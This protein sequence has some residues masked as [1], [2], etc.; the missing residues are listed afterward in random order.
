VST[1]HRTRRGER[2]EPPTRPP[3]GS[4]ALALIG[5]GATLLTFDVAIGRVHIPSAIVWVTGVVGALM[6]LMPG[7]I[8]LARP[9]GTR[10]RA[11]G[12]LRERH[13]AGRM[14]LR[15]HKRLERFFDDEGLPLST[16]SNL[17]IARRRRREQ[18]TR[19]ILARYRGH[20]YPWLASVLDDAIALGGAPSS[21]R[22]LLDA[23][24]VEQLMSL[25][26]LFREIADELSPRGA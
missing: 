19:E 6:I 18:R 17:P 20:L 12:S 24:D 21:A 26:D 22:Q 23:R 13:L 2:P 1:V 25:S 7:L 4:H 3:R 16:D 14:S 9:Q 5:I 10:R 8:L 11:G 15:A